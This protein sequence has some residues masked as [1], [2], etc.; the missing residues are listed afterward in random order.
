MVVDRSTRLSK[1]SYKEIEIALRESKTLR[2]SV[3]KLLA[4]EYGS[5]LT[6]HVEVTTKSAATRKK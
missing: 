4:A 6:K 1:L 3:L 5:E 2:L